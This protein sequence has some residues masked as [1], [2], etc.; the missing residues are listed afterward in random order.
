MLKCP[1]LLYVLKFS[2][3]LINLVSI[4]FSSSFLRLSQGRD[5]KNPLAITLRV[6]I[7]RMNSIILHFV[8]FILI[9]QTLCKLKFLSLRPIYVVIIQVMCQSTIRPE[10]YWYCILQKGLLNMKLLSEIAKDKILKIIFE[11]YS[12]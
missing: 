6:L 1:D 9:D 2:T 11:M 8:N 3:L 10:Q 12:Y 4:F 5:N 7:I